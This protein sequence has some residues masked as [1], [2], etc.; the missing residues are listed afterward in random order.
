MFASSKRAS[1]MYCKSIELVKE[2]VLR[3]HYESTVAMPGDPSVIWY[4]MTKPWYFEKHP[5]YPST[6]NLLLVS[7]EMSG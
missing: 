6:N 3:N 7:P 5:L 2:S 4:L 1:V